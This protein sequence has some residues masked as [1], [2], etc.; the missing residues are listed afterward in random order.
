MSNVMVE[1]VQFDACGELNGMV[2]EGSNFE[3]EA[4]QGWNAEQII[5]FYKLYFFS[6]LALARFSAGRFLS[7]RPDPPN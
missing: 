1:S 3:K 4:N 2:S 6:E 5:Y 7:A